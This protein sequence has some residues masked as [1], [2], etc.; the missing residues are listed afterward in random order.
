[1]SEN[2][3]N[4]SKVCELKI[5]PLENDAPEDEIVDFTPRESNS[6]GQMMPA[7][8][9][10]IGVDEDNGRGGLEQVP[11]PDSDLSKLV[12]RHH[13]GEFCKGR[14]RPSRGMLSISVPDVENPQVK[15]VYN[16]FTPTERQ[17]IEPDADNILYS[18]TTYRP[19]DIAYIAQTDQIPR[20][21][22]LSFRPPPVDDMFVGLSENE[23]FLENSDSEDSI[24]GSFADEGLSENLSDIVSKIMTEG[25]SS[26]PVY[27][28][29]EIV[30]TFADKT[31]YTML[32]SS[33]AFQAVQPGLASPRER[34]QA[35]IDTISD[36]GTT[37]PNPTG[38]EK[39]SLLNILSDLQPAGV[40]MAPNDVGIEVA[41]MASDPI[42]K[43]SFSTKFNNLFFKDII[44]YNVITA[45]TVYEDELRALSPFAN[46]AQDNLISTIDPTYMYDH[47]YKLQVE[48]LSMESIS[49]SNSEI[50]LIKAE[51][52]ALKND[53]ISHNLAD[54]S[55]QNSLARQYF[56]YL[57]NGLTNPLDY[58]LA[59]H[60]VPSVKI[61]GY[62]I[63]KTEV[64]SN[65]ETKR[66]PN[67][68]IDDPK[69]FSEFIDNS[70]RYGAVYNYRIR[71]IAVVKSVVKV[72]NTAFN[73]HE[74]K[75]AKYIVLSD[76]KTI[77]VECVENVPPPAPVRLNCYVDYKF[78]APVITWEFPLNKQR[79]IKRF[80]IFKRKTIDE[81]FV[82]VAEYDFDNSS[83]RVVPN[84]T[85]IPKSLF[86]IE[87]PEKKFR[88]D[89]FNLYYDEAIYAI[90]SVDARGLSSG[91]SS[92]MHIKYDKYT[93]VLKKNIISHRSAPKPYP[94]LYINNDFFEDLITSSG[95]TRCTVFFDPEYY[96]IYKK[97]VK[98]NSDGT[99][100][101]LD[102]T[103]DI[104]YVRTSD[105]NFN[106]TLQMINVDLQEEQ[107]IKI[108]I[109]DKTGSEVGV[110]ASKISPTNLSF[111]F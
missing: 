16:Y 25:G 104:D 95:R 102:E 38:L 17:M 103:E 27:T 42:S 39:I 62:A 19:E 11:R 93:N 20:F 109:V 36:D 101:V 37:P 29:V 77:S 6:S 13:F 9:S 28:G 98:T 70:V 10:G 72:V 107:R 40:A 84:E 15:F 4:R 23:V 58:L 48:P 60:K 43:Q 46:S 87:N 83:F 108:R 89:D 68:F 63:Q 51:L 59:K 78:R 32:A 100:E 94:N 79:D 88:D 54:I 8:S 80:Q 99:T 44:D 57:I 91:Y 34:A 75:V 14:S 74:F 105:E 56:H 49:V 73:T 110:P 66:Y 111:E 30:D 55:D 92:Q 65:G 85:A 82:L 47:D 22:R 45:N 71:T 31:I 2:I 3:T 90:A 86:K 5:Q 52:N 61:I 96:K 18:S 35:F 64:L 53:I 7:F 106:Y 76:G 41:Q 12:E 69:T 97:I 1:M 33:M 67:T 81:P 50:Q 26:N 24:F 21:V